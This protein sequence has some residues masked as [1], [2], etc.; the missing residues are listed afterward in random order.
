MENKIN[1]LIVDDHQLI[2]DGIISSLS[3]SDSYKIS[4]TNSCDEALRMIKRQSQTEAFDI[5]FNVS[6][7]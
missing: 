1:I 5:L 6:S 3:T 2:I 7:I 4:S